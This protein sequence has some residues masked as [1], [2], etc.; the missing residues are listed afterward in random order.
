MGCGSTNENINETNNNKNEI[1]E[2][3]K[4]VKNEIKEEPTDHKEEIQKEPE[5]YYYCLK[6]REIS[7]IEE[8]KESKNNNLK[9][10]TEKGGDNFYPLFRKI[11]LDLTKKETL[12]KDFLVF[13]I[14]SN[15]RKD[16]LTYEGE[17]A[18]D[19][20]ISFIEKTDANKY[21]KYAKIN[22]SQK[23]IKRF[24]CKRNPEHQFESYK[25]YFEF[26]LTPKD[27][28]EN[29]IT[30]EACYKIKLN[31]KYGLY[32]L[33]FYADREPLK[34]SSFSF[35]IDDNY[36]VC[37]IYKDNFDEISKYKLYSFNK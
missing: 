4:E 3:P 20:I 11:E 16:T 36:I 17:P 33:R 5:N 30:L 22:N 29:L 10:K 14:P 28:E 7:Y 12:I 26:S 6:E 15:Y 31:D 19:H 8:L 23:A 9:N 27:K 21:Q 32:H 13:Y 34:T 2:E 18:F 1:K 24:E 37:H 25:S 35:I